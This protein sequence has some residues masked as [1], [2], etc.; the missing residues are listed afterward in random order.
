[1]DGSTSVVAPIQSTIPARLDRLGW[2]PVLTMIV[3]GVV[4]LLIGINAEGTSLET[5]TMPLTAAAAA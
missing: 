2:S 4:E 5:V 1:V 3:G